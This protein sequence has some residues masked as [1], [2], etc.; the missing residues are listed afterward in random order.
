MTSKQRQ[1]LRRGGAPATPQAAERARAAKAKHAAEADGIE[2]LARE[3]SWT[4][5]EELHGAMA[6]SLSRLLREEERRKGEP[7]VAVT[8]RVREFRLGLEALT[9][10]RS[11]G[12]T[13]E[14]EASEFFESLAR[15]LPSLQQAAAGVFPLTRTS[16]S[17]L[18]Y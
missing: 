10:Y 15:R 5:F 13:V 17:D 7:S 4:A 12:R 3:A 11:T 18:Q 16:P 14:E 1:N 6:R 2:Q 8:Q 9:A